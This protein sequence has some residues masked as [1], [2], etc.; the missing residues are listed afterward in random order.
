MKRARENNQK[1]ILKI[2]TGKPQKLI[3]SPQYS[4]FI[5]LN[6]FYISILTGLWLTAYP[7]AGCKREEYSLSR[8]NEVYS[9]QSFFFNE[10]QSREYFFIFLIVVLAFLAG[11]LYR[12]NNGN[13][14]SIKS[15]GRQEKSPVTPV[16]REAAEEVL[17]QHSGVHILFFENL[18]IISGN[19]EDIAAKLTPKLKQLFILLTISSIDFKTRFKGITSEKLNATLWPDHSKENVKNN[20]NVSINHL[21]SL[22]EEIGGIEIVYNKNLWYVSFDDSVRFD[23]LDYFK[24]KESFMK[25]EDLRKDMKHLLAIIGKGRLLDDCNFDWLDSYKIKIH[26]DIVSFLLKAVQM[27]H[28]KMEDEELLSVAQV[29]LKYDTLNEFAMQLKIRQLLKLGKT[30]AARDY[31]ITYST[32]YKD[33]LGQNYKQSFEK[34]KNNGLFDN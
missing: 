24:L 34:I 27:V 5:L 16:K 18:R 1:N 9:A 29:I 14:K 12:K 21:R 2:H 11:Y 33:I 3:T 23:L 17:I 30:K 26:E 31:F 22:L 15:N 28:K 19:G 10:L 13:G 20:R 32:E 25:S 6:S 7:F 8:F 4:F